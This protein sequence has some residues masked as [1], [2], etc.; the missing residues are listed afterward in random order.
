MTTYLVSIQGSPPKDLFL[1]EAIARGCRTIVGRLQ[2]ESLPGE[3]WDNMGMI[4]AANGDVRGRKRGKAPD[5]EKPEN[6]AG[7]G[8]FREQKIWRA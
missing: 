1:Q 8:C 3:D 5:K 4:R 7:C 6:I 2:G